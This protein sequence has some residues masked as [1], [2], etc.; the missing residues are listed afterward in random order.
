MRTCNMNPIPFIEDTLCANS[1]KTM[2]MESLESGLVRVQNVKLP[3]NFPNCDLND[4]G[5]VPF[6]CGFNPG[7]GQPRRWGTCPFGDASLDEFPQEL[8]CYIDCTN[9]LGRYT[10]NVC[11]EG[12]AYVNFAQI[13]WSWRGRAPPSSVS[14]DVR[15]VR[16]AGGRGRGLHPQR[17]SA[18]PGLRGTLRL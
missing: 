12:S 2:K 4:D 8:Q 11:T 15:R 18:A 17:Q 6:F 3:D 7:R 13:R 16:P 14:T 1:R 5:T 9:S 10:D